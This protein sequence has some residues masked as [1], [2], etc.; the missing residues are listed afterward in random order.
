MKV[1]DYIDGYHLPL[2][3]KVLIETEG[4]TKTVFFEA[5]MFVNK[6]YKHPTTYSSDF[7]DESILTEVFPILREKY[8][9]R[10]ITRLEVAT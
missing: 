8:G 3:L 2:N 5:S 7:S 4:D 1:Y 6:L 9:L 10:L